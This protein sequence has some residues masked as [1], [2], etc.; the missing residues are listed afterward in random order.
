MNHNV[1]ANK[2]VR[3]RGVTIAAAALSVALVAPFAQSVAFPEITAAARAEEKPELTELKS[4]QLPVNPPTFYANSQIDGLAAETGHRNLRTT[5]ILAGDF[6]PEGTKFELQ[7]PTWTM[8]QGGGKTGWFGVNRRN[9]GSH[10]RTPIGKESLFSNSPN[11]HPYVVKDTGQILFSLGPNVRNNP[12]TAGTS[13]TV[14]MKATLE[15]VQNRRKYV[16]TFEQE[17]VVSDNPQVGNR[18]QRPENMKDPVFVGSIP[19]E[20]LRSKGDIKFDEGLP[21]I[22]SFAGWYG[23]PMGSIGKWVE[24]S[25]VP[26]FNLNVAHPEVRTADDVEPKY[27]APAEGATKSG[28]AKFHEQGNPENGVEAPEGVRFELGDGAPEGVTVDSETGVVTLDDPVTETTTVPVKAVYQDGSSDTTNVVFKPAA[29]KTAE[30]VE[31]KYGVP[32]AGATTSGKPTF[33][34]QDNSDEIK[35]K[36]AETFFGKGEGAPEGVTVD[37]ETGVVTL[38]DPVT[39][40]TTVPVKVTYED[41]SVDEVPVVFS[42]AETKTAETVEPKYDAP[43]EGATKSGA[44][45]FHEQGNP[46]NGVEAPEGVRFELGDR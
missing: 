38:D 24:R 1:P 42:P 32:A 3:R 28:A 18:Q 35:E 20:S 10:A 7:D 46:E 29:K 12:G 22:N 43:A 5:G 21:N 17:I 2:P 44:A 14:P 33:H 41:G 39:E 25:S 16:W 45:K 19:A 9:D 8:S 27:D 11:N 30:Q 34:A 37:S 6:F 4:G 31:P 23:Q 36:P 40:T 13:V 26:K 15:D